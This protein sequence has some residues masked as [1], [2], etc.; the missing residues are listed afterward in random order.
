MAA[1]LFRRAL[2]RYVAAAVVASVAVSVLIRIHHESP[3]YPLFA[4]QV[5]LGIAF[6]VDLT[7]VSL[8][9]LD[10]VLRSWATGVATGT[11]LSMSLALNTGLD[12]GVVVW[13]GAVVAITTTLI[14]LLA[15][16]RPVVTDAMSH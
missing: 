5:L 7:L 12:A 16:A 13:T 14:V 10:L 11:V 9:R 6:Y 4:A 8:S 3:P 1:G 2:L 15:L